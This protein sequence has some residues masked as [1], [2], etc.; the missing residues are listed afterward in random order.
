MLP[1][2]KQLLTNQFDAALCTLG[3]CIDRCPEAAWNQRVGSYAFCQVVFH[4]LFYAD[5]Y[6]GPDEPSLRRQPFHRDKSRF[7]GDYEELEDRPPVMLYEKPQLKT[8]LAHCRG[9]AAEAI[10]AETEASLAAP[11]GFG[12]L[13][14][15]RGELYVYNTRH[16]Q[17]H[18][19]QLSLR[20]RIDHQV[21]IPWFRSGWPDGPQ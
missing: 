16:T 12:W 13:P 18:A 2:F 21:N 15:T 7:F 20:L 3:A 9:K 1:L 17:H 19:A 6:L 8:Y 5:L 11:S 10:A 14:F 4:A